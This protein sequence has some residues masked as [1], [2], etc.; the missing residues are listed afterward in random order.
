LV[1]EQ[2]LDILGLGG[3]V[4]KMVGP[5]AEREAVPVFRAAAECSE[6]HACGQMEIVRAMVPY[7]PRETRFAEVNQRLRVR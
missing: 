5:Q 6:R 2:A 1:A 3:A 7:R 4:K